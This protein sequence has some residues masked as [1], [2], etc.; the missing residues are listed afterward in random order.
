MP[1]L[2]ENC[3]LQLV[4]TRSWMADQHPIGF[5]VQRVTQKKPSSPLPD[6]IVVKVRLTVDDEAFEQVPVAHID[7]P[8]SAVQSIN[9]EA[10]A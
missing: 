4:P 7:I 8:L 9:V 3:Y 2:T 6:A 5:S 1:R 10:T